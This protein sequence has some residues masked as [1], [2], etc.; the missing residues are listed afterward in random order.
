MEIQRD[1]ISKQPFTIAT[2][3]NPIEKT[4]EILGRLVEQTECSAVG[5]CFVHYNE[6]MKDWCLCEVDYGMLILRGGTSEEDIIT[7]G[8]EVINKHGDEWFEIKWKWIEKAGIL[9][10]LNFFK[11]LPRKYTHH[12]VSKI[13][14]TAVQRCVICGSVI[15]D[16][17]NTAVVFSSDGTNTPLG[18][19]AGAVYM[20][21]GN[22]V[23]TQTNEPDD[24][25]SCKP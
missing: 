23:I 21:E 8:L 18:Y 5:R 25:V 4:M 7:R 15:C 1:Y 2:P 3:D 12:V 9:T 14:E 24:Y 19:P 13:D 17:R 11:P 20:S 10:F 22:P 6:E 16:Y